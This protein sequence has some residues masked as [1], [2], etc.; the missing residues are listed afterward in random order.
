MIIQ[1]RTPGNGQLVDVAIEH[2]KI[3]A[4]CCCQN[5]EAKQPSLW[6]GIGPCER[7]LDRRPHPAT[8]PPLIDELDKVGVASGVTTVIDAGSTRADD[9]DDFS[10][11]AATCKT[12]V[13]APANISRIGLLRQ[14]ELADPA[15]I[16]PA[17]ARAAIRR[18]PGFI[19]GNQGARA[20]AAWG[21]SGLQP[22]RMAKQI[23]QANGN[24][25]LMVHVG[26]TPG[27]GRDVALLGRRSADPLLQR[28]PNRILTP[29][30]NCAGRCARRY[31]RD[32]CST[33]AMALPASASG[34]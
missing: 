5:P 18:H 9:V 7:R 14:N 12:R 22:L 4:L 32:S 17:L 25:P 2:G 1:G 8:P 23:Q 19:V 28:Q 11:S 10:A 16:D 27:S 3:A 29:A 6:A 34:A 13:H 15:D 24:L 20:A 33:S 21:E 31:G 30:V 26:N